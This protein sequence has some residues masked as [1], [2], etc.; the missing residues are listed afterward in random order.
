MTV[1]AVGRIC[2]Y[3][4]LARHAGLHILSLPDA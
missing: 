2:A 3:V 1:L 4:E